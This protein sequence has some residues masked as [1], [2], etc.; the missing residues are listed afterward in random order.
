MWA[1]FCICEF[2]SFDYVT[3]QI[4]AHGPHVYPAYCI[5]LPEVGRTALVFSGLLLLDTG[6]AAV[7]L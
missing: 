7:H 4:D 3:L 2:R 5:V 6:H 1:L